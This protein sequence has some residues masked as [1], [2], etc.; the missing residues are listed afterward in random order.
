MGRRDDYTPPRAPN[1]EA[2]ALGI[3]ARELRCDLGLFA[4]DVSRGHG[5]SAATWLDAEQGRR[6]VADTRFVLAATRARQEHLRAAREALI[7][8]IEQLA[9]EIDGAFSEA[10]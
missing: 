7:A 5:W 10:A 4:G 6:S 3:E 1:D 9:A 8:E 2:L